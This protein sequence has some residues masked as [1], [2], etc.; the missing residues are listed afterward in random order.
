MRRKN[1]GT[2]FSCAAWLAASVRAR[3]RGVTRLVERELEA[4]GRAM[5]MK[6]GQW[7]LK[8]VSEGRD[9]T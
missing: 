5:V 8:L 7:Q 3:R 1:G 6:E 4:V 2:E 9:S